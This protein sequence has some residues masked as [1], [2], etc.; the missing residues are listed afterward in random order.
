MLPRRCLMPLAR[1]VLA[2]F[3]LALAV[4]V[5]TPWVQPRAWQWVCGVDGQVRLLVDAGDGGLN[6]GRMHAL[7]CVLCLPAGAPPSVVVAA[8]P[9]AAPLVST[10][11]PWLEARTVAR[12]SAPLPPRGPPLR[13]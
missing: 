11:W 9:S 6:T 12:A 10:R 8:L 2:S 1:L 7:D 3:V 5:L 13:S 4:A